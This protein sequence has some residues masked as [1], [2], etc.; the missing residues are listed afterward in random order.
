MTT[1]AKTNMYDKFQ[2]VIPK[3]IRKELGIK[4]NDYVIEWYINDDGKVEVEFIKKLTLEEMVGRYKTD[5]TIDAL[6]LK[7]KFKKGELK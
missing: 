6:K 5:E 4:D 1:L 3:E 7:R 2:T